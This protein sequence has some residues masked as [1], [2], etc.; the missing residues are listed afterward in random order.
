MGEHPFKIS[1][2]QME[3]I[4]TAV[5][6]DMDIAKRFNIK[7]VS[8]SSG[9]DPWMVILNKKTGDWNLCIVDIGKYTSKTNDPFVISGERTNDPEELYKKGRSAI[10]KLC[11]DVYAVQAS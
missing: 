10:D 7:L 3:G 5:I 9:L 6:Q 2:E 4:R 8:G 11:A 1:R